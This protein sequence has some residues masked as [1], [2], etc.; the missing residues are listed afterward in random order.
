MARARNSEPLAHFR[1]YS[2]GRQHPGCG[3][4]GTCRAG[5]GALR[6]SE[7]PGMI[8]EEDRALAMAATKARWTVL[9][10]NRSGLSACGR[11]VIRAGLSI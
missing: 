5:G 3:R 6:L 8:S 10:L 1:R 11:P 7:S 2:R 9:P 4:G